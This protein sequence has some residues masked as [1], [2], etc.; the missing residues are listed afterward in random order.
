MSNR[1]YI[2]FWTHDWLMDHS[3]RTCV[4]LARALWID[5]ICLMHEGEPYGHLTIN[6]KPANTRQIA[7]AT[8]L[9]PKTVAKLMENLETN[10][11]FSKNRDGVIYSRR[12][13]RD[14]AIQQ[15]ARESGLKGGPQAWVNPHP[16]GNGKAPPPTHS[17]YN[18][19]HNHNQAG[20]NPSRVNRTRGDGFAALKRKLKKSDREE[21]A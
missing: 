13:V 3:L 18:H 12:M 17:T 11:V 10:G 1:G 15:K 16:I 8:R 2:R 5:L 14:H 20:V 7:Y 21:E 4:P 6:G 19:N 9:H